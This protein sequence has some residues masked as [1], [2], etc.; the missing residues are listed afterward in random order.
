[1]TLPLSQQCTATKKNG[2][3]C[4]QKALPDFDTCVQH[5]PRDR[6]PTD[7]LTKVK[8]VLR[9]Q[10]KSKNE[11][12][13]RRAAQTLAQLLVKFPP[14][15]AKAP[16]IDLSRWTPEERVQLRAILDQ[17]RDL[18][19]QVAE[20]LDPPPV[21]AEATSTAPLT[22]TAPVETEPIE[23]APIESPD[24]RVEVLGSRGLRLVYRRELA[25]DTLVEEPR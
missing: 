6:M 1:M 21:A 10:L 18:R 19:K 24:D 13:A 8:R 3:R 14:P 9:A 17:M 15:E 22:A 20:R 25:D 16:S 5:T 4:Q 12:V 7:D 2:N 11:S 23:P